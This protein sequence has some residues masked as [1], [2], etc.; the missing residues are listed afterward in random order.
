MEGQTFKPT[1]MSFSKNKLKEIAPKIS[2]SFCCNI[3]YHTTRKDIVS[4]L[5]RFGVD[6]QLAIRNYELWEKIAKE[7]VR[8]TGPEGWRAMTTGKIN[9]DCSMIFFSTNGLAMR[10]G[11]NPICSPVLSIALA[12]SLSNV[13]QHFQTLHNFHDTKIQQAGLNY[14]LERSLS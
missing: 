9:W 13:V 3:N 2:L 4:N 1:Y 11:I 7:I 6:Q 5:I 12:T 10:L 14:M 8:E